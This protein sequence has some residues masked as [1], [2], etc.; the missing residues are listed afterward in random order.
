M[1]GKKIGVMVKTTED[2]MKTARFTKFH[3][4]DARNR[5]KVKPIEA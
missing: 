4:D 2:K 5:T 1:E 3:V